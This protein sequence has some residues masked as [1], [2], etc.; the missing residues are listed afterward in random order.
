M[1]SQKERVAS[2]IFLKMSKVLRSR[3]PNQC[4]SHH[5]KLIQYHGNIDNIITYYQR[6]VF[7]RWANLIKDKPG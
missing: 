6:V 7:Q 2:K 4:R 1:E 3:N 5:Q